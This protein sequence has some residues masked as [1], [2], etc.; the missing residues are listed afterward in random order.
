MLTHPLVKMSENKK[1]LLSYEVKLFNRRFSDKSA[2]L[3]NKIGLPL[4][5][6]MTVLPLADTYISG[7][8]TLPCDVFL[9]WLNK[10]TVS[11][12]R[13][14]NKRKAAAFSLHLRNTG[15]YENEITYAVKKFFKSCSMPLY[16]IFHGKEMREIIRTGSVPKRKFDTGLL[17]RQNGNGFLQKISGKFTF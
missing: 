17:F 12:I 2:L 11:M 6:A 14:I 15:Y 10:E 8:K 1:K 7:G 4:H 9:M 13:E 5:S 16:P 3:R